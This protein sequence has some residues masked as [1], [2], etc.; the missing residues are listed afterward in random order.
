MNWRHP[1]VRRHR[2]EETPPWLPRR[3]ILVSAFVLAFVLTVTAGSLTL[4]HLLSWL[5][6]LGE[7]AVPASG[8]DQGPRE[9]AAGRGPSNATMPKRASQGTAPDWPMY[10][11]GPEHT[12]YRRTT[13]P[14]TGRE[15]AP[16]LTERWRS[17]LKGVITSSAAAVAG[18]IYIGSDD[19]SLYAIDA[20]NGKVKWRHPTHG[21]VVSSP[22]WNA[23]KVFFTSTDGTLYA[24]QAETGQRLWSRNAQYG[25]S[26]PALAVPPGGGPDTWIYVGSARGTVDAID[27]NGR[28]HWSFQTGGPVESSPAVL[29]GSVYVGS[30]DDAVYALDAKTGSLRWSV[31]TGGDVSASP[32]VSKGVV[33]VGSSD[34][35]MYALDAKNG[36]PKWIHRCLTGVKASAVI[37]TRGSDGRDT[38]FIGTVGGRML[39]LDA[40]TGRPV[41]T[42]SFN[43]SGVSSAVLT[44]DTLFVGTGPRIL[45]LDPRDGHTAWSKTLT[46][47]V[48]GSPIL[49]GSQL[50]VGTSSH[51][52][53]AFD[54]PHGVAHGPPSA[55]RTPPSA[56]MDE[57]SCPAP[58]D[59]AKESA[60]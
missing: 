59:S 29:E 31:L 1:N 32:A 18:R 10:R 54:Q 33:Y 35:K 28:V 19:R 4:P 40:D 2:R 41:W 8:A 42:R 58:A 47:Q 57:N 39:S 45:A 6:S 25:L 3:K 23:G 46:G 44:G 16:H 56:A 12:G 53:Y 48:S 30:N 24:L 27:L 15:R 14:A 50:I 21:K 55:K 38:I 34:A 36:H 17:D 22:A 52:L 43:T 5:V 51:L 11:S 13:P 7:T 37:G 60:R 20:T 26:S 9:A 49:A